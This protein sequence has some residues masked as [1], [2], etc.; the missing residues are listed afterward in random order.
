MRGPE[1]VL[2]EASVRWESGPDLFFLEGGLHGYRVILASQ[3]TILANQ[4]RKNPEGCKTC[5]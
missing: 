5:P 1:T 2:E 4:G 3:A